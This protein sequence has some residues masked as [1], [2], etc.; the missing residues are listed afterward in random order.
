MYF[1]KRDKIKNLKLILKKA[2]NLFLAFSYSKKTLKVTLPYVKQHSKK[3][4]FY[5]ENI[6]ALK[7]LGFHLSENETKLTLSITGEKEEII[8][9][10][11]RIL[12]KIV[13]DIFRYKAFDE[14]CCIQYKDRGYTRI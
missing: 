8:S 9:R 5:A 3:G 10:L 12:S 11:K 4:L 6:G 13:F 14:E 1:C 7:N 2:D